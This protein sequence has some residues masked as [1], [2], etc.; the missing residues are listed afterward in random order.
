MATDVNDSAIVI[1]CALERE[2]QALRR[3]LRGYR[4]VQIQVSG[5]GFAAAQ[6]VVE[7]WL[8][9][10]PRPHL[11]V[12]AGFCGALRPHLRVGDIV[13]DT[14][15]Q[16]V[17][18]VLMTPQQKQLWASQTTALAVDLESAAVT[19]VCQRYGVPCRVIRSVSDTWDQSIP[20]EVFDCFHDQRLRLLHLLRCLWRR[21]SLLGELLRLARQSRRAARTLARAV[22]ECVERSLTPLQPLME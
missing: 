1:F 19:E 3:G 22:Q 21:P 4:Q 5:M 15:V 10:R 13:C 16:T 8:Q 2:A 12:A 6:Q 18:Q 17:P 20:R 14:A 11:V 9:Q 7:R